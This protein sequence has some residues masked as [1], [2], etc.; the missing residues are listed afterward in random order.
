MATLVYPRLSWVCVCVTKVG[1]ALF[2]GV[3]NPA[4]ADPDDATALSLVTPPPRE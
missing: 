4:P 1:S 3:P 2:N